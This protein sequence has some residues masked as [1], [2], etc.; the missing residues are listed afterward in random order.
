MFKHALLTNDKVKKDHLF[1][2]HHWNTKWAFARKLDI[3]TCENNMLSSYVKIS[4][5]LW[6]HNKLHLSDKNCLSKM[7]WYFIGV[8]IINRTLHG[9]LEIRN[10]SSRVEKN[11]SLFCC[12]HSWN[13]F[14]HSKINFV[15]PRGH[16]ISS[17][18]LIH[19]HRSNNQNNIP[20]W[21]LEQFLDILS[22]KNIMKLTNEYSWHFWSL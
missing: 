12:A 19:V 9:R 5:L 17:I 20:V 15:S 18:S 8:Y 7:V 13:I 22:W 11:I 2:K 16:V 14:Q 21:Y 6:H 1:Y 3:F 10:F 4:L